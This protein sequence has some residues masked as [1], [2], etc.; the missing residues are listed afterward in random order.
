[1][2]VCMAPHLTAYVRWICSFKSFLI[3]EEIIT[4]GIRSD[5]KFITCAVFSRNEILPSSIKR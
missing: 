3:G 2:Y 5:A 4:L 1:M